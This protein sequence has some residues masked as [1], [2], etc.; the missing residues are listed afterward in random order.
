MMTLTHN[1]ASNTHQLFI[2]SASWYLHLFTSHVIHIR[3]CASILV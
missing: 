3:L 1:E 2:E